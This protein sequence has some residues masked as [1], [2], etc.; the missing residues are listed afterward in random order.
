MAAVVGVPDPIRTQAVKAWLVLKPEC[1]PSDDL[2]LEIQN[3][4]RTHLGAHEYPRHVAFTD[5]LP[6]TATGKIIRRELRERG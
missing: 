3:F 6:L 5:S 2:V 4:V 1:A